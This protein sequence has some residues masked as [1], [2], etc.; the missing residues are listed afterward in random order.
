MEQQ[1]IEAAAEGNVEKLEEIVKKDPLSLDRFL[2]GRYNWTPLHI[3]AARNRSD[4][5][6]AVLNK[7]PEL[8]DLLD[9]RNRTALHVASAKGHTAAVENILVLSSPDLCLSRDIDGR[10][11]LHLAAMGGHIDVL[12]TLMSKCPHAARVYADQGETILHLIMKRGGIINVD[13]MK[14]LV[15]NVSYDDDDDELLNAKDANGNTILH[16]AATS[17]NMVMLNTL[18]NNKRVNVN[19]MNMGGKTVMDIV[20]EM[21]KDKDKEKIINLLVKRGAL[22]GRDMARGEWLAK[23]QE[24]LMVVASLIATMA[25]QAG[26]SPP[27]GVWQDDQ[28][29]HRAGEA[30]LAYNYPDTYPYFLR[31]NTIGFVASLSTILLLISGLPF[32]K[33]SQMWILVVI[34]WL[35]ITAMAFT[36]AFSIVAITPKKGRGPM[37]RTM[38]VAIPI[39]CFVMLLLFVFHSIRLLMKIWKDQKNRRWIPNA[40]EVY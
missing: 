33:R 10:N 39:W 30:V 18:L 2:V 22:T 36:Y 26:V 20:K 17:H 40:N 37:R 7:T 25:F 23:Q 16:L 8:I 27:G 35:T 4:F 9:S 32:K 28:N 21:A 34:M 11:P 6:S 14:D 12:K 3:A 19:V 29:G 5:V 15:Q 24:S 13:A 38:Y 31:A 1:L